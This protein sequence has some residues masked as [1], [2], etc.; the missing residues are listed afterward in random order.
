M[1]FEK[2]K[3][4]SG[5]LLA[6]LIVTTALSAVYAPASFAQAGYSIADAQ[7]VTRSRNPQI[8]NYIVCL[9]Q[10]MAYPGMQEQWGFDGAMDIARNECRTMPLPRNA[11]DPSADDLVSSIRECGFRPGDASPDM[12]C[13]GMPQAA[14][15]SYPV[16]PGRPV[17]PSRP[18]ATNEDQ[19]VGIFAA[20]IFT[21]CDATLLARFWRVDVGQS[22]ALIGNKILNGLGWNIPEILRSS[23]QSG[24][25]CEWSDTGYEY[26]DAEQIAAIWALGG[27]VNEAKSKMTMLATAGKQNWVDA[28]LGHCHTDSLTQDFSLPPGEC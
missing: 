15:Q 9:Q 28:A 7:Y 23:R 27:G 17:A 5:R 14:P 12:G 21:Y 26:R 16:A 25:Q 19:A 18:V 20:S 4:R 22:K 13:G 2:K 3:H 11:N 24:N 1:V 10:T 8:L 6:S